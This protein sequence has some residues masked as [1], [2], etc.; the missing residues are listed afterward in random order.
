MR[1]GGDF[2]LA[3]LVNLEFAMPAAKRFLASAHD[4]I[5]LGVFKET[6][7]G[8]KFRALG[9]TEQLVDRHICRFSA[10]VPERNIESRKR[11]HDWASAPDAVYAPDQHFHQ[12]GNVGRVRPNA[13]RSNQR[14]QQNLDDRPTP[15]RKCFTP[16]D[17]AA[18]SLYLDQQ[19]LERIAPL[20]GKFRLGTAEFEL[21]AVNNTR[22]A[23]DFHCSLNPTPSAAQNSSRSNCLLKRSTQPIMDHCSRHSCCSHAK[24]A[25]RSGD[26]PCQEKR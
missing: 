1:S 20:T 24:Y 16:A 8:R 17:D 4:D 13:C 11:V 6:G 3:G 15:M 10:N 23:R 5:R 18:V 2:F 26:E 9:A 22:Y 14:L 25:A 21:L 12:S 7:I 19:R